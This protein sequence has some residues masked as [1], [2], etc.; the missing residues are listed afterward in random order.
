MSVLFRGIRIR[1]SSL[2][3]ILY[4]CGFPRFSK[5]FFVA[6]KG[7]FGHIFACK[8]CKLGAKSKNL[9]LQYSCGLRGIFLPKANIFP[10]AKRCKNYK[11]LR[12]HSFDTFFFLYPLKVLTLAVSFFEPMVFLLSSEIRSNSSIASSYPRCV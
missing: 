7:K 8:R 2:R 6:K 10:P 1:S 9:H 11:N 5:N 4:L 12:H 3:K